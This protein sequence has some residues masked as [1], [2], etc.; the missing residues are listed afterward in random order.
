VL[1]T[2]PQKGP[3]GGEKR[4]VS[5]GKPERRN[6]EYAGKEQFSFTKG[7]EEGPNGAIRATKKKRAGERLSETLL[8]GDSQPRETGGKCGQGSERRDA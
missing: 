7:G 4:S 3:G 2:P 8:D 1:P 5:Q 6:R